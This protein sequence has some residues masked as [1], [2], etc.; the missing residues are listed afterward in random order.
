MESIAWPRA[1]NSPMR[2]ANLR[3]EGHYATTAGLTDHVLRSI[4]SLT[5]SGSLMRLFKI[6]QSQLRHFLLGTEPVVVFGGKRV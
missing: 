5:F 1:A 3:I 2:P 6:R 4:L